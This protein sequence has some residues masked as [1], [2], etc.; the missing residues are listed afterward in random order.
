MIQEQQH[1]VLSGVAQG[2]GKGRLSH[3]CSVL[4][5]VLNCIPFPSPPSVQWP[6]CMAADSCGRDPC[7]PPICRPYICT[8]YM[9]CVC[10][11]ACPHVHMGISRVAVHLSHPSPSDPHRTCCSYKKVTEY[12][13]APTYT[14]YILTF[15]HIC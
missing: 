15:R 5:C 14:D 3:C 1:G 6:S 9:L 10:R 7:A 4:C 2:P 11:C 12:I 13:C 8:V